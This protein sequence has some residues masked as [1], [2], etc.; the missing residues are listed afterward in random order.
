MSFSNLKIGARLGLGF[1][2]ALALLAAVAGLGLASMS[3]IETRLTQIVDDNNVKIFSI[4]TVADNFRDISLAVS[5]MVV[6]DDP[7]ELKKQVDVLAAA[8]ARYG[9]A[10]KEFLATTLN[11]Q[12]KALL[13]KLDA[14]I[15]F[16][17][18]KVDKTVEFS[19]AGARA[20]AA[21]N[22]TRQ[23]APATA[24]AIAVIDEIV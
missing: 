14:A 8:R 17:K 10:K 6:Q 18:P 22:M 3:R 15:G 1:A 5:N 9:K 21:E 13:A 11:E 12:E 20:E 4:S 2:L 16:A 23:S 7:A 24:A 19:I